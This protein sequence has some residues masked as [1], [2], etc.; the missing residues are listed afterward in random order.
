MTMS[1][2]LAMTD[3]GNSAKTTGTSGRASE[4]SSTWDW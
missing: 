1:S 2:P 4:V 3:D